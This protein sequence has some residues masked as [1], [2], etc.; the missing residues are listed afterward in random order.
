MDVL[1]SVPC[2]CHVVAADVV[3][4]KNADLTIRHP[5]PNRGYGAGRAVQRIPR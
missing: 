3:E 1:A 5:L 2:L 4:V